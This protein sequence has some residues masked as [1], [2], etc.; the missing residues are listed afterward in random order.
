MSCTLSY[1][2]ACKSGLPFHARASDH[3][4]IAS[5]LLA[6]CPPC[7][8]SL[9]PTALAPLAPPSFPSPSLPPS[10]NL[11]SVV[12]TDP[13]RVSLITTKAPQRHRLETQ[14]L[15]EG[16]TTSLRVHP[17]PHQ[18]AGRRWKCWCHR[19]PRWLWLWRWLRL[20][21][22]SDSVNC[23]CSCSHQRIQCPCCINYCIRTSDGGR[24]RSHGATLEWY[25]C[26][27]CL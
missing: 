9:A 23:S 6:R 22:S 20:T 11:S 3:R 17:P 5:S 27:G 2:D 8:P 10:T 12:V 25:I 16:R 15:V 4:L 18:D 14:V 7:L 26:S 1:I 21:R 24:P 13:T 19:Q